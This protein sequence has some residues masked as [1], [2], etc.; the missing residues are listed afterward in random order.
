MSDCIEVTTGL[1]SAGYGM[2]AVNVGGREYH[3]LAH[4][5]AYEV[6]HGSIPKGM[7]VCHTCDNRACINIEHLFLG[8]HAANLLDAYTKGR[9]PTNQYMKAGAP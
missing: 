8:D 4:R 2:S 6:E 7:L 5:M 9:T 3:V 1:S